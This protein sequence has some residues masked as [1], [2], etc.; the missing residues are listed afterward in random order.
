M[1]SPKAFSLSVKN[2]NKP[3]FFINRRGFAADIPK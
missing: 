2:Q 3:G 1:K